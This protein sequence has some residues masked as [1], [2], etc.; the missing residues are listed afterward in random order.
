MTRDLGIVYRSHLEGKEHYLHSYLD[1]DYAGDHMERKS[2]SG[3]LFKYF[4]AVIS[5]RGKKQTI[6]AQSS[7]ESEYV[8][9][10]FAVREA[11]WLGRLFKDDF[12]ISSHDSKDSIMLFADNEGD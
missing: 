1:P 2:K 11:I 9:M 10:S 3:Y 5:W 8:A 12:G 4:H 6:V 7:C